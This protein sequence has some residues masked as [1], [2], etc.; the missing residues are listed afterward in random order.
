MRHYIDSEFTLG[1]L[2][3]PNINKAG[4]TGLDN[5]IIQYISRT[6]A[7]EINKILKEHKVDSVSRELIINTFN[8]FRE[9][10]V[11]PRG[12]SNVFY[13]FKTQIIEGT[14]RYLTEG[15]SAYYIDRRTKDGY[16]IWTKVE[17]KLIEDSEETGN[18]THLQSSAAWEPRF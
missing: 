13:D 15:L 10:Y 5:E 6:V 3:G 8:R 18:I 9:S 11:N 14:I 16:T 7:L 12:N 2:E 4:K 1:S 17:R